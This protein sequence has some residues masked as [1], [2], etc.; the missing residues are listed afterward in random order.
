MRTTYGS[1]G[2]ICFGYF[3]NLGK[4]VYGDLANLTITT[5]DQGLSGECKNYRDLEDAKRQFV[6]DK[7]SNLNYDNYLEYKDRK[8][9]AVSTDNESQ[10]KEGG[11][12]K[13]QTGAQLGSLGNLVEGARNI[14]DTNYEKRK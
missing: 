1:D 6:T 11:I 13:A 8:T 9:R 10:Y 4:I 3:P 12:I 7:H 14:K 2:F 5:S